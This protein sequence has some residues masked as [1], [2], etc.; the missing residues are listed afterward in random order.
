MRQSSLVKLLKIDMVSF[1]YSVKQPIS[2][3]ETIITANELDFKAEPSF[4]KND[5]KKKRAIFYLE[6]NKKSKI[7]DFKICLSFDYAF[8]KEA[9]TEDEIKYFSI[10][11][12]PQIISFI[13]GY[14]FSVTSNGPVR[15]VLPF[16]DV[17]ESIKDQFKKEKRKEKNLVQKQK[18]DN[19]NSKK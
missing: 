12:I 15:I 2:K 8:L 7:V 1:S 18:S 11:L 19:T 5:K 13:R 4:N 10:G 6:T 3:K 14:L 9:K 16:I 17:I